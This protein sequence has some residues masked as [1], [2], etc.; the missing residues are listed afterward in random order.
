M[1]LGTA[2]H[3]DHGKTA[4]VKALSGVD[5]DRLAEE[6][7]R[8]ITIELG[9]A[10]Y[11]PSPGC[12]FGIVDV[13]GHEAFVR[14]MV[15]GATGMDVALLVVAADEG[16]M[17]QTREHL[18]VVS[19]LGVPRM[20]VALT[21]MDL[22]DAEWL[23]LVEED[24]R[25]LL[26]GTPYA[27]AEVVPVSAATGEGVD[28][29][30]AALVRCAAQ[31]GRDPG[32]LARLPV[33][34]VFAL[35]GAGTVV[36]GT[37]WSGR[38]ERGG[39]VRILPGGGDARI[40]SVEVHG[41]ARD[42]AQAGQ[43]AAVALTGA[44][45]RRGRLRRGDVL[46]NSPAWQPSMML[47]AELVALEGTG[48]SVEHGQRVRVHLGTAEVLGRLVLFL[49]EPPLAAEPPLASEPPLA[50]KAPAAG[51]A[52][53]A[54]TSGGTAPPGRPVLVQ[55]RLEAPV[56]ARS[57]DRFVIRS[58]SPL[59]TI[60]GGVVLEPNPPKRKRLSAR[61]REALGEL[62][63]G[64]LDAVRGAARLAGWQGLPA[65][66]LG[67]AAGCASETLAAFGS[68]SGKDAPAWRHDDALFDW[69][70]VAQGEARIL[71]AAQA[72]HEARPLDAGAPLDAIRRALP[73]RSHARLADGLAARL[74]RQERLV[75]E[76]KTA[77]LPEFRA[78]LRPDQERV[79]ARIVEILAEAGLEGPSTA[80]LLGRA[81]AGAEGEAVLDFLARRGRARLVGDAFW[82]SAQV[83]DRA[84]AAVT[85]RLG[86]RAG[87]GPADFREALP[88]ARKRLIPL[89]AHLDAQGVTVREADGRRVPGG[90]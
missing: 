57:G 25:A 76:G 46:V 16:V 32:D 51:R 87:L 27:E 78:A 38:L 43:R 52:A 81:G 41:E 39:A 1:I 36:T 9:F 14:T 6:K 45:V 69:E 85:E 53:A 4:L 62:G 18:A 73:D 86:G 83:L 35:E 24:A 42:A 60:A 77:R 59:A 84:A 68:R 10:P 55:L 67:V 40:R 88:V 63:R 56:V 79:A 49:E 13:P 20:V 7:K 34:R 71:A 47:T 65:S 37:L 30:S 66:A 21:K 29:L 64:G 54:G 19:L 15:A 11:S 5:T 23:E 72:H 28:A 26:D 33:D 2:G 89:L 90:S 31:D 22:V 75:L 8:G 74:V 61:E 12:A 48:W 80:A 70:V 82:V 44:A 58:Y 17:P 3:I 50:A